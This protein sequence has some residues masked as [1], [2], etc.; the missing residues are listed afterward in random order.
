MKLYERL[1]Q[2]AVQRETEAQQIRNTL[3]ILQAAETGRA[4]ATFGGKLKAAVRMQNGNGAGS[5][6]DN[7]AH[8]PGKLILDRIRDF[9]KTQEGLQGKRETICKTLNINPKSFTTATRDHPDVLKRVGY[10]VYALPDAKTPA[11]V[12]N[13]NKL[14][15]WE[16]IRD[17]LRTQDGH[18]ARRH[19]I[20][21]A[22]KI[23]KASI[24]SAIVQHPKMFKKTV[25]GFY[26]LRPAALKEDVPV[27][28]PAKKSEPGPTMW[29]RARDFLKTQDGHQ[30]R[31]ADIKNALGADSVMSISSSL[32]RH[33][34]TF[35]R[36]APGT[37]ALTPAAVREGGGA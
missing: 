12:D 26:A 25:D 34:E 14:K 10:G 2:L 6:H 19:D 15:Q 29:E 31:M 1:E 8:E 30:G 3:A 7:D 32:Y 20:A 21:T 27:A 37:F 4:Q 24:D 16:R 9:L 35:K 17:F 22:T 36:V 11:F 28:K 13:P 33:P 18:K 23:L 5:D